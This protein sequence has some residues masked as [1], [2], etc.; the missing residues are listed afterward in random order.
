ME[1][2][3]KSNLT[4]NQLEV[5]VNTVLTGKAFEFVNYRI[6]DMNKEKYGNKYQVRLTKTFRFNSMPT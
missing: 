1:K 4:G 2:G 3:T 5:A 6:W